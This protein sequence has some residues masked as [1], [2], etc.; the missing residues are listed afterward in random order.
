MHNETKK[1]SPARTANLD[2]DGSS[3]E[4]GYSSPSKKGRV[5]PFG[6]IWR[7]GVNEPT[8]FTTTQQIKI[9]NKTLPAGTYSL[10]TIPN[11][12]SWKVIFNTE[13]PDWGVTQVDG[14]QTTH[15]TKNDYVTVD[16]S[17]KKLA[18]PIEEFSISFDNEELNQKS[19]N[20][21]SLAYD[22]TK[23]MVP[24]YK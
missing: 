22:T 17:V 3:L 11:K 12:E 16:V 20:F 19:Q 21:L 23:I 1:I 24:I 14:K 13:V 18:V 7:T 5:V 8:T 15:A 6:K 4:V 2:L 9:I 10:W